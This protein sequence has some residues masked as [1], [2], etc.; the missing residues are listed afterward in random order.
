MCS[1]LPKL[2][3]SVAMIFGFVAQARA[4]GITI[5]V[6]TSSDQVG[7]AA[8]PQKRLGLAVG[9]G[10]VLTIPERA[11]NIF[12]ADPK[13]VQVR[14]SSPTTMFV[15]GT[16][17]GRTTVAAMAGDGHEIA[18]YEVTVQPSGFGANEA[19]TVLRRTLPDDAIHV[20]PT[21]DGLSLSGDVANPE[22]AQQAEQV[23]GAY[24]DGKGIVDDHLRVTGS[25]EV[26][27]KVRI[28]EMS[29]QVM[30]QLGVNWSAVG[31]IAPKSSLNPPAALAVAGEQFAGGYVNAGVSVLAVIDALASDDLA[32]MLAEPNLVAMSGETANFLSGGEYPIP[33]SQQLG[34]TTVEYKDY[35]VSLSFVPTVLSDDRISLR[36]RPEVSQITTIGAVTVSSGG[37]SLTIPALTVNRADTTVELG[38]G[39]TFAIAGLLQDNTSQS[40]SSIPVLGDIP[41]LGGFFRSNTLQHQQVELVFLVTP[42]IVRAPADPTV[43]RLPGERFEQPPNDFERLFMLRQTASLYPPEH[44]APAETDAGFLVQ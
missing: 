12:V 34:T 38:S 14:P 19:S 22:Q 3:T 31:T 4:Q 26:L 41:Y 17:P 35:G 25:T 5:P 27:L 10:R 37:N 23:A 6:P 24:L 36:V 40:T 29:R 8:A 11:A 32:R 16:A 9:D 30:R 18:Q 13:V 28:A 21:A 2:V 1:L 20:E 43:L 44:T 39:Q 7:M 33:V 15:F 42:Y